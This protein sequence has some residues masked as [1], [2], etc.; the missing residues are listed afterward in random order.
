M[1]PKSKDKTTF[2]SHTGLYESNVLSFGLTYAPPNFQRLMGKVLHGLKWKICLIYKDNIIIFSSTFQE[3]LHRLPLVFTRLH[4]TNLT[5]KPSK[6][7][8]ASTP[9]DFLA[10]VVSS[11]G[12]LPNPDKS[13]AVCSFPVPKS[14]KD[15]R[16]FLGLSNYYCRFIEGFSK[17]ASPLNH[18]T[19]QDVVFSWSPECQSAFQTLKDRLCSPPILSYLDFA[20]PFNLFTDASQTTVGY[21]LSP[22]N[23]QKVTVKHVHYYSRLTHSTLTPMHFFAIYG[24]LVNIVFN[25]CAHRSLFHRLCV[26]TCLLLCMMIR[27]LDTVAQTRL[28]KK[29]ASDTIGQECTRTLSTGVICVLAVP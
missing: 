4:E 14:V 27:L 9:V 15:L 2:I 13:E 24:H 7:M 26:M 29:V 3:H 20:Q 22:L 12:I 5:L 16:S 17:I 8:F 23:C 21:I 28:M 6:C 19:H 10:F 11:D 18:L 1:H 25:H